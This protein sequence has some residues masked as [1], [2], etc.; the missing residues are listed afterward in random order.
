MAQWWATFRATRERLEITASLLAMNRSCTWE[1]HGL[2]RGDG[3]WER[4]WLTITMTWMMTKRFLSDP[5]PSPSIRCGW[6]DQH[7]QAHGL[8]HACTLLWFQHRVPVIKDLWPSRQLLWRASRPCQ[9]IQC[10]HRSH[11][12][13]GMQ[14]SRPDPGL[15]VVVLCV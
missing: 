6:E 7:L 11:C 13:R 15:P 5:S 4:G 8:G 10:H 3:P 2:H 1:Q 14:Y 9:A 12:G